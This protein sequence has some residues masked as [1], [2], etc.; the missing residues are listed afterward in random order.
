M[1]EP[2]AAIW[3]PRKAPRWVRTRQEL[4]SLAAALAGGRIMGL[5]SEADSLHG[6]PEKVCLVQVAD[7]AG[8][9]SL[10]DPLSIRDLSPLASSLADPGVVK[11][12]HGASY[13]VSSMKRD[14]GF[15]FAGLF[16][17]MIAAQ[18]L[19]LS[20]LGLAA[21]L[22]RFFGIP[23]R[24]SRQKDDW[25]RRPLSQEQEAY[26]VEDVQ[27]LIPLR[28]RLLAELR[29]RG[30][31]AWVR[32][33][34]E[35]LAALPAA[36]RVFDPEDYLRVK[37]AKDL[38]GRGLATLRELFVAREA[39]AQEAGRPPFKVL[40]NDVIVGI[41]GGRLRTPQDLRRIPGCSPKVIQRYGERIIAAIARVERIPEAEL[42]TY[43]RLKKPRVPP[44]VQRRIEALTRWRAREA[45]RLGLD[46]GL[47]LPRRLIEQL[48]EQDSLDQQTLGRIPGLRR[49]RIETFGSELLEILGTAARRERG[50]RGGG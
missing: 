3:S 30:R 22:E 31:D 11:V 16:D 42:P 28:E 23:P 37:G 48:A 39:W 32:E 5:D 44:A 35:A 1:S 26:A 2:R 21:L 10:V 25:A 33:E 6:F 46:P 50:S 20:E 15:E 8:A 13:D 12:F 47:L 41:A 38:D 17:T 19:G 29:E 7:Q 40:G 45:E 27:H 49:W 18:F 14:F 4:Q 24:P 36:R 9:V 43:P 34:C